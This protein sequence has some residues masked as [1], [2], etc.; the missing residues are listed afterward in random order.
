MKTREKYEVLVVDLDDSLIAGDVSRDQILWYLKR[1]PLRII[2]TLLAL[3]T[4]RAALK[5]RI[6]QEHPVI[7]DQLHYRQ[8]VIDLIK[9]DRALGIKTALVSATNDRLI[10]AIS[11]FVGLFDVAIGSS[12][13]ELVKGSGKLDRIR[14]EFDHRPFAYVG[15]TDIDLLVWRGATKAYVVNPDESL[16]KRVLALGVTYEI[17]HD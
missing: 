16:E 1:H 17:L 8:S 3:V 7:P 9:R 4:S 2:P 10:Q 5:D 13:H 6:A 12:A 11:T 15:D 14:R